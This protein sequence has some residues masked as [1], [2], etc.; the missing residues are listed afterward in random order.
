MAIFG[1]AEP[2]KWFVGMPPDSKRG[3]NGQAGRRRGKFCMPFMRIA[4]D[5]VSCASLAL[6]ALLEACTGGPAATLTADEL[7]EKQELIELECGKGGLRDAEQWLRDVRL[8]HRALRTPSTSSSEPTAGRST[9]PSIQV[10][11]GK[12]VVANGSSDDSY[13]IAGTDG[14]LFAVDIRR[15]RTNSEEFG[16]ISVDLDGALPCVP[17][18]GSTRLSCDT[19]QAGTPPSV[20]YLRSSLADFVGTDGVEPPEVFLARWLLRDDLHGFSSASEVFAAMATVIAGAENGTLLAKYQEQPDLYRHMLVLG[21]L[22]G[23]ERDLNFLAAIGLLLSV[24]E[25]VALRTGR[26]GEWSYRLLRSLLEYESWPMSQGALHQAVEA[27][28]AMV[29]QVSSGCTEGSCASATCW[30]G[31]GIMGRASSADPVPPA[32][33][34]GLTPVPA[35]GR[36]FVVTSTANNDAWELDAT[37][38]E[39]AALKEH[40]SYTGALVEYADQL[41]FGWD[42]VCRLGPPSW[43]RPVLPD[44]PQPPLWVGGH[45]QHLE[46]PLKIMVIPQGPP[47]FQY[48]VNL[49]EELRAVPHCNLKLNNIRSTIHSGGE[50]SIHV[51]DPWE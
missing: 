49:T 20:S 45:G 15:E 9:L 3:S 8:D 40:L 27:V 38:T 24:D 50:R 29:F 16:V 31:F 51:C 14:W 46:G 41:A 39:S 48:L 35:L 17:I 21:A 22:N 47:R 7:V 32:T 37:P 1:G 2:I 30:P 6:I 42:F 5:P 10:A 4:P 12:C 33:R 18:E 43:N 23:I 25:S 28:A 36:A 34:S 26:D 13:I 44:W 11:D 19:S